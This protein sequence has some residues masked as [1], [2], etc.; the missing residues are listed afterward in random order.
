[1]KANARKTCNSCSY[2]ILDE[3]FDNLTPEEQKE[4]TGIDTKI[5]ENIS[6]NDLE[7]LGRLLHK[8]R[9]YTCVGGLIE[10]DEIKT[11]CRVHRVLPSSFDKDQK[12]QS[13]IANSNKI[14]SKRSL[15]ITILLSL[16]TTVVAL[17]G[18]WQN[19]KNRA[20]KE[21]ITIIE[22]QNEKTVEGYNNQIKKL[23][24]S[25]NEINTNRNLNHEPK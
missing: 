6:K 9:R 18:I 22:S 14:Y 7:R 25:I 16:I 1:M 12:L 24:D 8:L 17:F 10:I 5:L 3:D 11:N 19:T 21:K 23:T 2:Y 15:S 20:L 4:F 13:F